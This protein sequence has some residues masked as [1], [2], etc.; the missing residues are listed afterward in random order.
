M[1]NTGVFQSLKSCDFEVICGAVTNISSSLSSMLFLNLEIISREL[2]VH[3]LS[4][5]MKESVLRRVLTFVSSEKLL[6]K[7]LLGSEGRRYGNNHY[8][9]WWEAVSEKK[10]AA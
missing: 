8:L 9:P 1:K 2:S 3:A 6:E 4:T 5:A 10:S 7:L